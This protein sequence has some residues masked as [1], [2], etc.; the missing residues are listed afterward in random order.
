M[1][2]DWTNTVVISG[3]VFQQVIVWAVTDESSE[4]RP[5]LHK[6]CGHKV[7]KLLMI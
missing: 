1:T 4:D 2:K 5:V 3:T 7:C 6:L